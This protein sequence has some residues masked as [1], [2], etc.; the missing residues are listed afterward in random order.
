MPRRPLAVALG[1]AALLLAACGGDNSSHSTATAATTTTPTT[2]PAVTTTTAPPA[3]TT[4]AGPPT[5]LAAPAGDAVYTPPSP[6]PVQQPGDIIWAQASPG[7]SGSTGY[8]V[9]YVS[10]TVDDTPIAVSGVIIVPGAD[11][12]AAPPEGRTVLTWAH[13]TTGL[14]DACAPS[15]QYP[16]GQVAEEALAQV[17]VGRG[18]VYAATDYQ[19]LGPPGPHPY[20]VGLSEGHNV[21]DIARAAERLQGS[22]ATATSNVLVWG[23]SQG[24]GAAAFAAELAPTYAPDLDVVGAMVGAP[25]TD[26]PAIATYDDGLPYFGFSFMAAAGFKAAYPQLSYDAI[27]NESGK[28]AVASIAE[29]CSDQILKDFAGEHASEYEIASP[30]D[31]PGWKEAFA[32]N[33]PGQRKTPVPIFIYQGDKDQII[34]VAVSAQ[35]LAKYC[36]LG[37]TA[38]RKTYPNTDHTSV[39]PAALGDILA[40]A[41]DRL[42]GRPAGPVVLRLLTPSPPFHACSGTSSVLKPA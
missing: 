29:A 13:G 7:P 16:S 34:P 8:T 10:T 24:G 6:L 30:Q 17:A 12:P 35:L 1:A 38:E 39:I 15:K 23:H 25:A 28:Q 22:G 41:N 9:L 32:A 4:A 20:V 33:E 31:A 36:A 21:L 11:A 3:P 40:F 2:T 26:F 42:A 18:F 19:G 27:L 37:V 5:T 14:G